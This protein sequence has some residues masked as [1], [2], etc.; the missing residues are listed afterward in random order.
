MSDA[1]IWIRLPS[2]LKLA[3]QL[4]A[5]RDGM[6]LNQ[7]I[8]VAVAEKIGAV[9]TAADFLKRRAGTAKPEDLLPFLDKAGDEAPG[10]DD[11]LLSV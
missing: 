10:P 2:S 7:W 4:L 5:R 11:D 6:L 1:P 8:V 3:A 9:E